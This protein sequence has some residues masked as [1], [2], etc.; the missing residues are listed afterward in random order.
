VLHVIPVAQPAQ[1]A[2]RVELL[3][4]STP[5]KD[6]LALRSIL[7]HTNWLVRWVADQYEAV[8]FLKEHA[9]PVIVCP[10]Q[11]P[12]ATWSELLDAVSQLPNPPNVLVYGDQADREFGIGVLNAGGYDLLTTPLQQDQVLRAIS[13]ACRAWHDDARQR[14]MLHVAAMTA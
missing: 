4:I 10:R 7:L 11:L 14:H 9:V 2:R 13:V 1:R 8:L 5:S 12:D 6:C 3:T